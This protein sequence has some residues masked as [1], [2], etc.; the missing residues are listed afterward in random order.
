MDSTSYVMLPGQHPI[1]AAYV[2]K[3]R[4]A[5]LPLRIQACKNV[6]GSLTL[7]R[8]YECFD[9]TLSPKPN[10]IYNI[11]GTIK[12]DNDIAY[13]FTLGAI[14]AKG[15]PHDS[16]VKVD[17][18]SLEASIQKA[19]MDENR[20]KVSHVARTWDIYT[21]PP[22]KSLKAGDFVIWK[23]NLFAGGPSPETVFRVVKIGKKV[24]KELQTMAARVYVKYMRV[25][26]FDCVIFGPDNDG[27]MMFFPADSRRLKKVEI[28]PPRR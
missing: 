17:I 16:S 9:Y 27:D 20:A 5:R 18:E 12:D 23:E 10:G 24:R 3:L 19:I 15:T 13:R 22:A 21:D 14:D 26:N 6:P 1:R 2:T 4:H 8:F 7:G 11:E 28:S 25:E